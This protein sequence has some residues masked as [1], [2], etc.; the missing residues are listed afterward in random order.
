MRPTIAIV[1]LNY[2]GRRYLE[3]FLPFVT[4][5]VCPNGEVIV[6]DKRFHG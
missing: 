5:N 6:A 3:Q 1:I 4:A 2:N